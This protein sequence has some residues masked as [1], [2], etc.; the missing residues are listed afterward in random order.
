M[1]S[2]PNTACSRHHLRFHRHKKPAS[3]PS[4]AKPAFHLQAER[5]LRGQPR[6]LNGLADQLWALDS[7]D[8]AARLAGAGAGAHREQAWFAGEAVLRQPPAHRVQE[9]LRRRL[10]DALD[11]EGYEAGGEGGTGG[12]RTD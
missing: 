10:F 5:P 8:A 3:H 7:W 9:L 4:P 6:A 11:A 1:A 2:L 12:E